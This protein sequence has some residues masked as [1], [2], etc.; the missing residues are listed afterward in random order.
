MF[1]HRHLYASELEFR[2]RLN[3][4]L[5]RHATATDYPLPFPWIAQPT[6]SFKMPDSMYIHRE[7]KAEG[8]KAHSRNQFLESTFGTGGIIKPISLGNT[9]LLHFPAWFSFATF[10]SNSHISQHSKIHWK[11]LLLHPVEA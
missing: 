3:I 7:A 1:K 2:M 4:G 11:R 9:N 5:S 8:E 6:P 10:V